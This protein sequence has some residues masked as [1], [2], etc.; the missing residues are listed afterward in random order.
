ME[1]GGVIDDTGKPGKTCY[2]VQL[3]G[4]EIHE[5][6][7]HTE[8]EFGLA[9][10]N[11]SPE[12]YLSVVCNNPILG[13]LSGSNEGYKDVRLSNT[14]G[15]QPVLV[16]QGS[17][18]VVEAQE[19]SARPELRELEV[20]LLRSLGAVALQ[21]GINKLSGFAKVPAELDAYKDAFGDQPFRLIDAGA[22]LVPTY[23]SSYDEARK[24]LE[25][26]KQRIF[27]AV[28]DEPD[29]AAGIFVGVDIS[30]FQPEA[31]DMPVIVKNEFKLL[32]PPSWNEFCDK[33]YPEPGT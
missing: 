5:S 11:H 18:D 7:P 21:Q 30:G 24:T 3:M 19:F 33:N 6:V 13:A 23:F 27:D 1:F 14:A 15:S 29:D 17:R 12:L 10:G 32:D 28:A 26:H 22:Q 9:V 20:A 16:V 2:N 25:R 31:S 8:V 4:N